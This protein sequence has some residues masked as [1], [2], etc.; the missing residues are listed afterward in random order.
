MDKN[1]EVCRREKGN[2]YSPSIHITEFNDV[3]IT[4]KRMSIT[5][6]IEPRHDVGQKLLTV[7]LKLKNWKRKLAFWLLGWNSNG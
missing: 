1:I 3:V 4:V 5:A 6:P 2:E 7:D